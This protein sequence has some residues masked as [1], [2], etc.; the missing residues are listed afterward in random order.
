M[1]VG[2]IFCAARKSSW[3][4]LWAFERIWVGFGM[5]IVQVFFFYRGIWLGRCEEEGSRREREIRGLISC[6]QLWKVSFLGVKVLLT[7]Q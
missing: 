5:D 2:G 7:L 6:G 1:R 3:D 4:R